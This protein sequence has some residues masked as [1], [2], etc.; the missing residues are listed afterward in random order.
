MSRGQQKATQ[1]SPLAT[2]LSFARD[3]RNA[4]SKEEAEFLLVNQTHKL[5][6]YRQ[7]AFWTAA[8]GVRT[9]SGVVSPEANA[10][11]IKWLNNFISNYVKHAKDGILKPRIFDLSST[12]P[13][14]SHWQD[15]LPS[16]VLLLPVPPHKNFTGGVI[17]LARDSAFISEEISFL[18][19]W[20]EMWAASYAQFFKVTAKHN[21]IQRWRE[22]SLHGSK[23]AKW[24]SI[25]FLTM[26]FCPVRLTVIAPAEL[27]PNS[28]EYIRAPMDGVI[29]KVSVMPNDRVSLGQAL[30]SFD[31]ISLQSR[32]SLAERELATTMAEYRR[33]AQRAVFDVDSKAELA[34]LQS[35]IDE[36]KVNVAYLESLNK[37]ALVDAPIAGIV[38]F[39]DPSQ[40]IGRPVTTGEKVMVVANEN[41]VA[42]EAWLAPGDMIELPED[43]LLDLYL[44]ND[45]FNTLQA[46]VQYISRQAELRPEG[47]YAYRVRAVLNEADLHGAR[48]GH[49]G[50][51]KLHGDRVPFI[52]WMFRKP[53]ASFRSWLGI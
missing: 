1:E 51:A 29:E 30:F 35:Q 11:Y 7:S 32:L 27:I 8:K 40:W 45:P 14:S 9:L 12:E 6:P 37:R 36:K 48:I 22:K 52:Y 5:I 19:E 18:A 31:R 50:T 25:A 20:M 26:L 33:L 10:P 23:T 17:L 42:V 4:S 28:P 39:D 47:F 24:M 49:K 13:E 3:L 53:L 16:L 15:W 21:L 2:L 43:N 44:V 41:D 38:L 46:K 34:V